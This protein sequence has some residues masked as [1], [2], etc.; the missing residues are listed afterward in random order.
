MCS[1]K[2]EH[3]K[4]KKELRLST[5]DQFHAATPPTQY[6]KMDTPTTAAKPAKGRSWHIV[7]NKLTMET[8][9]SISETTTS[10]TTKL[11]GLKLKGRATHS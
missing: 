10:V 6:T 5:D 8:S 9:C 3:S 7:H 4:L 1:T 11:G 2:D